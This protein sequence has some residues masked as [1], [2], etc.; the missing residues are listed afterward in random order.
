MT[1]TSI[2]AEFHCHT[3]FSKDSLQKP[4]DLVA[5]CRR[6]GIGRVVVTDHNS[7]AGAQIA[8]DLAP[9]LVVV[10]EEIMTTRGEILAAYVTQEI[11]RGLEPQEVIARLRDQGAFISVSHPM[12]RVRS[13]AWKQADL[14]RIIDRVDA[15]EIFNSRCWYPEDNDLAAQYAL[16]HHLPGTAGSD[17][18][19]SFELGRGVLR[20]QPF[21]TADE[22][23]QSV[24]SAT[25]VGRMSS[26]WVHLVSRWASMRK[27]LMKP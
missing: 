7:I 10:G 25:V 13:G 4:A 17:A 14:D 9:D 16:L 26:G 2:L 23:R 19:A 15:I 22:L 11:P 27:R 20:M 18:H 21:N 5:A 6:K 3:I 8:R 24:R 1:E 12:D